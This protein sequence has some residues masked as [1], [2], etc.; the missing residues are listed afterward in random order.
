MLDETA[1]RRLA[2]ELGVRTDYAENDS[3][4][5]SHAVEHGNAT[6]LENDGPCTPVLYPVRCCS[7]STLGSDQISWLEEC[8]ISTRLS[9]VF[10]I[11]RISRPAE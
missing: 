5:K 6:R 9:D 4:E 7:R 2:R 8:D 1:I 3:V 11:G 10:E